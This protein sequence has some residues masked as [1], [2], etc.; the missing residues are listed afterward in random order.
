MKRLS[1]PVIER[2]PRYYH[3]LREL[4]NSHNGETVSSHQLAEMMGIDDTLVRRDLAAISVRG[5]PKVG[6]PAGEALRTIRHV[7]GLDERKRAILVGAGRLGGAIASYRGFGDFGLE[8]VAVFDRA[9]GQVGPELGGVPV[10]PTEGIEDF[11]AE[12]PVDFAI[13]T[14]PAEAAQ[15]MADRLFAAGVRG[16]WNFAPVALE[17]PEGTI[18]R[19][20]LLS[21]GLAEISYRLAQGN[22]LRDAEDFS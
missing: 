4:T 16:L 13:L 15:V 18:I 5:Q 1:R 9:A 20:E 2:L 6:Y 11:L 10:H 22:L 14:L 12:R 3:Y 17:A 21:S 19:N 7:L 8:I